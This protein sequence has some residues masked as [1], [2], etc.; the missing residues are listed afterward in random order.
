VLPPKP[1]TPTARAIDDLA[2][3]SLYIDESCGGCDLHPTEEIHSQQA[4]N[5]ATEWQSVRY[6]HNPSKLFAQRVESSYSKFRAII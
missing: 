2:P 4:I 5:W 3:P 1:E 6:H